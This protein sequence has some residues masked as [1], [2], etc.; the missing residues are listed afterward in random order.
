MSL[1]VLLSYSKNGNHY[2]DLKCFYEHLNIKRYVFHDNIAF[3]LH[4]VTDFKCNV[5]IF[6][7]LF[8][9]KNFTRC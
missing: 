9:Q 3:L 6:C 4:K 8:F 7:G 5:Q 2:S 1:M